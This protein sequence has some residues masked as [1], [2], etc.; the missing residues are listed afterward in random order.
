MIIKT[1]RLGIAALTTFCLAG[2][3]GI[4]SS[5]YGAD[6]TAA[7]ETAEATQTREKRHRV[8]IT[9]RQ[10]DDGKGRER[11]RDGDRDR[12]RRHYNPESFRKFMQ[13][14]LE[15]IP[16]LNDRMG[17]LMKIQAERHEL[18]KQRQA[19]A[20]HPDP[21]KAAT[22]EKFHSLL[23]RDFSLSDES[24]KIAKEIVNDLPGIQKQLDTRRDSLL[25][26][27]EQ[28]NA[29]AADPSSSSSQAMD[30]RR[31]VRYVDFLEKK[32]RD[33]EDH[34]ERLD[35]L[36]RMMRGVPFDDNDRDGRHGGA[37]TP[38]AHLAEL[39]ARRQ[40]LQQELRLVENEINLIKAK[41]I[42]SAEEPP[43]ANDK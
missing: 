19:V 21:N 2:F 15:H 10:I 31:K 16:G 28:V 11:D 7:N 12:D 5:S 27:L 34:P 22:I 8:V 33:L 24:R 25:K 29:T 39:K 9:N 6:D 43:A 17:Q 37:R 4:T 18:Q 20:A 36:T 26:E 14:E 30:L 40:E 23:R 42:N 3:S 1:R 41:G 32:L 38:E 35:V 13:A